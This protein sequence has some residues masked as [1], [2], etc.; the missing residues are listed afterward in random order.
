MVFGDQIFEFPS[1]FFKTNSEVNLGIS[2]LKWEED[3]M[4]TNYENR[5]FKI[6]CA[7]FFLSNNQKH[8][9]LPEMKNQKE[10]VKKNV[11]ENE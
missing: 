7:C 2:K 3:T 1:S 8:I 9:Y 4:N 5:I 10:S 6:N 11:N